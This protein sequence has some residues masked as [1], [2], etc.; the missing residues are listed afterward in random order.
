VRA[1]VA[2]VLFAAC[3]P[4]SFQNA[5]REP[6]GSLPWIDGEGV[7]H[8]VKA[9]E[10]LY[11]IAKAYDVALDELISMNDVLDPARIEKGALLFIPRA[12]AVKPVPVPT[13]QDEPAEIAAKAEAKQIIR[14]KSGR[15]EWPVDGIVTSRFGPRGTRK[16]DGIDISAPKGTHITAAE[17]GTVLYSGSEY[18]G[19][20]NMII[21]KHEQGLVT[22]YAHN[23]ENAVKEGDRVARGQLIAKVGQ[24]GRADGPHLH[25][26]VRQLDKPQNPL[27]Y[28]P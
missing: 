19:Y 10:T 28:L 5:N 23:S 15:L 7:W 22:I 4:L 20:G 24:T 21:V 6:E 3:A 27:L 25:F 13:P 17:S 18:R 12:S 14:D 9:G 2:C 8:E 11:R 1:A 26:E 16:H